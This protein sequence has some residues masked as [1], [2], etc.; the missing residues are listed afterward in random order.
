MSRRRKKPH[1]QAAHIEVGNTYT[2]FSHRGHFTVESTERKKLN[3]HSDAVLLFHGTL[4]HLIDD[5]VDSAIA[6]EPLSLVAARFEGPSNEDWR[7]NMEVA[8]RA[9]LARSRLRAAA[10]DRF[11]VDISVDRYSAPVDM[12][13]RLAKV[14]ERQ[15]KHT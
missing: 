12:V 10:K 2:V 9:T 4:T 5:G 1:M 13:E 6:T 15:R 8:L 3:P 14:I 11:G 7:A